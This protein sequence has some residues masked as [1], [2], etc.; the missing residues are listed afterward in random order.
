MSKQG[1]SVV[2]VFGV[3]ILVCIMSYISAH[4]RGVSMENNMLAMW[5]NNEQILGQYGQKIA[6]SAQIPSIQA[7]D[8]AKVFTDTLSARYGEGGSNAGMQWIQEQNP[9]LDSAVYTKLQQMI[10]AGRDD[11]KF[12]QTK[13]ISSKKAYKVATENFWGG[14]WMGF[15]GYPKIDFDDYKAITTDRASETFKSGKE[16]APISLRP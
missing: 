7:E 1:W 14:M 8:M 5:K 15:A 9:N 12:A 4:N 2:G 10:E 3:L 6:E 11:F 16:S 13:F